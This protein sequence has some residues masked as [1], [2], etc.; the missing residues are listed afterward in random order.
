MERLAASTAAAIAGLPPSN[1]D[2]LQRLRELHPTL[3]SLWLCL[4]LQGDDGLCLVAPVL[5][6]HGTSHILPAA[7]TV[8]GAAIARGVN[9]RACSSD[10]Q[11]CADAAAVAQDPSCTQL[12]A[13]PLPTG[14]AAPAGGTPLLGALLLGLAPAAPAADAELGQS[15][16]RALAQRHGEELRKLSDWLARLLLHAPWP[17]GGEGSEEDGSDFSDEGSVSGDDSGRDDAADPRGT[18]V[19]PAAATARQRV[20]LLSPFPAAGQERRFLRFQAGM[21]SKLDIFSWSLN[22]AIYLAEFYVLPAFQLA[23]RMERWEPTAAAASTLIVFPLLL[24]APSWYT[25]HRTNIM[26]LALTHRY[27]WIWW[28]ENYVHVFP[29]IEDFKRD[30]FFG[31][32]GWLTVAPIL[33]QLPFL[34]AAWFTPLATCWA[35]TT[36]PAVCAAAHPAVPLLSCVRSGVVRALLRGL[37]LPVLVVWCI[38][39]QTRRIFLRMELQLAGGEA[40]V[41]LRRRR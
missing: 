16:A 22:V 31:S 3:K 5:A 36:M 14:A 40:P 32:Y 35:L 33:F 15:L 27:V 19:A 39:Q 28:K 7:N 13:V 23:S 38:E 10:K 1:A 21:L 37:L 12:L 2:T 20:P 18:R 24:L 29:S 4:V 41:A 34:T 8:S 17:R 6:S 9:V 30:I 25:S 11:H 26:L